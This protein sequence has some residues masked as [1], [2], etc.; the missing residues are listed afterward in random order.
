MRPALPIAFLISLAACSG[1]LPE[2]PQYRTVLLQYPST[3]TSVDS[4]AASKAARTDATMYPIIR[5]MTLVT[6]LPASVFASLDPKPVVIE[7][8][9]T[10]VRCGNTIG[11]H[12]TTDPVPTSLDSAFV[13][14]IGFRV[15]RIYPDN[16]MLADVEL[17]R[18]AAINRLEED[19]H[20][21][22]ADASFGPC[23]DVPAGRRT[24]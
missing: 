8:D 5:A 24:G 15:V 4:L 9:S 12:I 7:I 23:N 14:S 21:V 6:P 20:I 3:P 10:L 17:P 2:Y 18:I 13:I 22:R 19:F 16:L 1:G 11:M